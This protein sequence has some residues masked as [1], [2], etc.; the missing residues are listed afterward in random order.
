MQINSKEDKA[1]MWERL[2]R[3]LNARCSKTDDLGDVQVLW[4]SV[5]TERAP[6]AAAETS[7]E[8]GQREC[9]NFFVTSFLSHAPGTSKKSLKILSPRLF[10]IC[11][12]P[13]TRDT[14]LPFHA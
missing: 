3:K 14:G 2:I 13:R 6:W 4:V 12:S 8:C 11:I 10:L 1:M 5:K 9:R 7:V